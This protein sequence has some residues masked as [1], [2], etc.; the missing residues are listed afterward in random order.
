MLLHLARAATAAHAEILH[1][2]A[3][4]RLLV[5][6]EMGERN[7]DVGIHE[8]VTDLGL[9]HVLAALHRD[10]RLVR[11][12]EAV[13]DD[14]L[15]AGRV[16][17]EPVPVRAAD[18]FEGV[19]ATAHIQGVAIRQ[20]GFAAQPLHHVR[21]DARVVGAQE[22]QVSQLA[23]VNLDGDELVLEIDLLDASAFDEAAQLVELALTTVRA[24]V[25][26]VHL[27]RCG[28][29]FGRHGPSSLM[30]HQAITVW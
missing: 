21:D 8:R 9:L 19:L 11:A 22:G 14:D 5:A 18:V 3:E 12:L 30:G 24:Q 25:G 4:A 26:A 1:A 27:R 10:E 20:E 6:L 16:G 29:G 23:E 2:A 15:A 17:R 13:G 7:D 28:G